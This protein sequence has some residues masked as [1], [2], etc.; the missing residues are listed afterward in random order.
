MNPTQRSVT[1]L[2]HLWLRAIE[3]TLESLQDQT[4]KC[5][6][7]CNELSLLQ[8]IRDVMITVLE[9]ITTGPDPDE[10]DLIWDRPAQDGGD[11]S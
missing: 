9:M 5:P 11:A 2:R 3:I 1:D 10:K 7:T 4:D 8:S 6:L